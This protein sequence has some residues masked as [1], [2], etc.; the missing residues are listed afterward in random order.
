M[1]EQTIA[2]SVTVYTTDPQE[3]AKAAEVLGRAA[4]GLALDGISTS[5]NITRLDD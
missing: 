3:V 1:S 4:A 5:M 2:V